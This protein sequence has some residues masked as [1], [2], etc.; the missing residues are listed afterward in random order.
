MEIERKYL[1]G[2]VP[3]RLADYPVRHM[4]QMYVSVSPVIRIRRSD[5]RY[6][7]TV[8]SGGLLARQEFE[9]ELDETE[10]AHLAAKSEGN[11]IEKDRYI[12][13]LADTNATCGD[14]AVDEKLVIELDVFGGAFAGL[15]YAEVEFPSVACAEAFVPP[16]WFAYDVTGESG[17][18]NSSLAMMNPQD[19]GRF[20]KER[21]RDRLDG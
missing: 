14:A 21:Y 19:I 20:I 2:G 13:P 12:I 15:V 8:K 3:L 6:V 5:D 9:M 7:L 1:V 17:Y 18:Q 16:T 4:E 10:Y 11:V